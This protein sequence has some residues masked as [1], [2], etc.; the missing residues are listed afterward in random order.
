MVSSWLVS[1]VQFSP[2]TTETDIHTYFWVGEAVDVNCQLEP[3]YN[4]TVRIRL[5]CGLVW[6]ILIILREEC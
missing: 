4:H 3:I 2:I 1:V 5:A 6:I